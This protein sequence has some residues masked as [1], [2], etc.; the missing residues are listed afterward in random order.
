VDLKTNG[1][2]GLLVYEGI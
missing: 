2:V 1:L